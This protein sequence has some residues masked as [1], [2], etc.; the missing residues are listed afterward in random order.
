MPGGSPQAAQ[1]SALGPDDNANA[2]ALFMGEDLTDTELGFWVSERRGNLRLFWLRVRS[3]KRTGILGISL[4]FAVA[5]TVAIG[6]QV[7]LP[8]G[9]ESARK[10]EHMAGATEV[11]EEG[12]FFCCASASN[13]QD[14]C[15]SCNFGALSGPGKAW[16]GSSKTQCQRC[17]ASA[18]WCKRDSHS[19][20][21]V[22]A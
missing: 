17:G 14:P 4:L 3:W 9:T 13:L 6:S 8:N 12:H 15:N 19:R 21:N 1:F 10:S 5:A 2:D 18:S 11:L 7:A 16:C 20:R 22:L